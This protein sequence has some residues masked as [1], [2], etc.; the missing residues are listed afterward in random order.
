[1]FSPAPPT[2]QRPPAAK[3][4]ERLARAALELFTTRGYHESTTPRIAAKAGVAEGT[5]YRHFR[6]K[7][8]LLNEIFRAGV[9]LFSRAAGN[10]SGQGARGQ[11][12][13]LAHAWCATAAREPT[14]ARLVFGTDLSRHL[15]ATSRSALG[16]LDEIVVSIIAAGKVAGTVREGPATTWALVWMRLVTL[17]VEQIAVGAWRPDEDAVQHVVGSAWNA[18]RSR[19]QGGQR[20]GKR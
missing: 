3:T 11:L 9:R 17:A 10:A 18:I 2:A 16:G 4:R 1:M 8:Q 6:G 13:E 5:I 19:D 12:A 20:L 14:V 7:E 15:D